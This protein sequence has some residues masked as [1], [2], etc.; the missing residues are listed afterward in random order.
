MH[1]SNM[2]YEVLSFGCIIAYSECPS[3][4]MSFQ[5]A[6]GRNPFAMKS[7]LKNE[8]STLKCSECITFM[9]KVFDAKRNSKEIHDGDLKTARS[10]LCPENPAFSICQRNEVSIWEDAF[11][12]PEL[13]WKFCSSLPKNDCNSNRYLKMGAL[14]TQR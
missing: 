8:E 4:R 13:A 12:T 6:L 3:V 7:V 14:T 1:R 10:V 5:Y 11:L 9:N 2:N